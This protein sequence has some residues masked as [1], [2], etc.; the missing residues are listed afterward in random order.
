MGHPINEMEYVHWV[1]NGGQFKRR[2]NHEPISNDFMNRNWPDGTPNLLVDFGFNIKDAQ[3]DPAGEIAWSDI[4]NVIRDTVGVRKIE[5]VDLK[6]N[7][8]VDDVAL[9][10]KEFPELG[11]VNITDG[12]TGNLL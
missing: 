10:V 9:D 11:A 1:V 7:G 6:L 12:D 2:E 5:S 8:I 3:G 4:F